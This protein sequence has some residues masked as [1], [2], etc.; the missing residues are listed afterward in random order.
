MPSTGALET[1]CFKCERTNIL[2]QGWWSFGHSLITQ[3]MLLCVFYPQTV[4]EAVDAL[5]A[6]GGIQD[7]VSFHSW[8]W[9]M[10]RSKYV[11]KVLCRKFHLFKTLVSTLK[12]E[13]VHG[14]ACLG[15]LADIVAV[16][17]R[18]LAAH[19]H[20]KTWDCITYSGVSILRS[21][22]IL[23]PYYF[24]GFLFVTASCQRQMTDTEWHYSA[25]LS[26]TASIFAKKL[27]R[28]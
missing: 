22:V 19:V 12:A 9:G 25:N 21:N 14:L 8:T 7:P 13:Y 15:N 23:V 5:E 27:A 24:W 2:E 11:A 26:P 6:A 16:D 17:W 18:T 3:E 28:N 10:N 1:G 20:N 4:Q